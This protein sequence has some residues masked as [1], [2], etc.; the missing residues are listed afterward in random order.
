M[1]PVRERKDAVSLLMGLENG[2]L[3]AADAA[4]VAEDLDPVLLYVI[5]TFLREVYPASDPAAGS[6][7]E[8]VV[9]MTARSPAV[10]RRHREGDQDP[11]SR[12]FE[13]EHDYH[14]F[15]GRGTDLIDLIVDKLES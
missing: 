4:I 7:L 15:K 10:V 9:Q 11:I 3:S 12:W 14:D 1:S 13:A 8:R 6:V 5:V 2:G